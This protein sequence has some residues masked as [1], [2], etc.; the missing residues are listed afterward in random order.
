MHQNAGEYYEDAAL[1]HLVA[2]LHLQPEDPLAVA[3]LSRLLIEFDSPDY[4]RE[5]AEAIRLAAEHPEN[6]PLPQLLL[7]RYLRKRREWSSARHAF[8]EFVKLGGDSG[9][10]NIETSRVVYAEDHPDSAVHFYL[11]GAAH[12]DSLGRAALRRDLTWFATPEELQAFDG[13]GK[14]AIGPW[15]DQLWAARDAASLRPNGDRLKEHLRRWWFVQEHFQLTGRRRKARFAWGVSGQRI[16][17]NEDTR[18]L[19]AWALFTPGSLPES[20]P[21]SLGVDDRGA[22]Y[23]RHGEPDARVSAIGSGAINGASGG[24]EI[25]NESWKYELP[26]GPIILHFCASEALGTVGPTTL[27]SMLPLDPAIMGARATLDKRFGFMELEL[28]QYLQAVEMNRRMGGSA[29]RVTPHMSQEVAADLRS[30]GQ[31]SVKLGLTTDSYPLEYARGLDP[32]IQI[33]GVGLSRH[34]GLALVV[35]AVRGDRI[36]PVNRD[37]RIVYPIKIRVTAVDTT[38]GVTK[39]LDTLRLFVAADTLSKGSYLYGTLEVPLPVGRYFVRTL[40][41]QSERGAAGAVGR[42]EVT[43][44]DNAAR[45]AMSDLVPG[46]EGSGLAWS[47]NG[48]RIPLNPL[49]VFREG[50][51]IELYYEIDGATP[52]AVYQ[53]TMIFRRVVGRDRRGK[54]EVTVSFAEEAQESTFP[55]QRSIDLNELGVGSYLLD[56]TVAENGT[57]HSVTRDLV[58]NVVPR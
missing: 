34:Q 20:D 8:D 23:M 41:E 26:T 17:I 16:E 28:L 57:Q 14:G 5:L 32:T 18:E 2:A 39:T 11:G 9:L 4:P 54:N 43:V 33:Y 45:L 58:I 56:V 47:H 1:R 13:L 44:P 40:L 35:F 15:I 53:T 19:G 36:V 10:G 24:C 50:S 38:A 22:V 49:N 21:R 27:V 51:S 42:S 52:H 6:G 37:G 7:G 29:R 55:V 3:L 46:G 30:Y 12:V 25:A 48:V 31:A